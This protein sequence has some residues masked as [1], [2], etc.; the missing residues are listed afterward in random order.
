MR[1]HIIKAP[2][3]CQQTCAGFQAIVEG[4]VAKLICD[5]YAEPTVS[6]YRQAAVHLAFW[7][8]RRR[9]GPSQM[10][11]SHIQPFPVAT[12]LRMRLPARRRPTASDRSGG[13]QLLR[14]GPEGC[15]LPG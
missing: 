14:G 1:A 10:K 8:S 2:Q 15:R 11:Q 12:Y 5:G 3:V 4:M 9:I 7:L 13:D 6:F